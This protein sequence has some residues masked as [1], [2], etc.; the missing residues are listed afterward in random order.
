MLR[1]EPTARG[2]LYFVGCFLP[3]IALWTLKLFYDARY[4]V[5]DDVYHTLYEVISLLALATSVLNIR[6]VAILS[7]PTKKDMLVYIVGIVISYVLAIGRY[8]EVMICQRLGRNGLYPEA[9]HASLRESLWMGF[10]CICYLAAAIVAGVSLGEY[11]SNPVYNDNHTTYNNETYQNE[12][13][14]DDHHRFLAPDES[15]IRVDDRPIYV[16]LGAALASQ[17]AMSLMVLVYMSMVE[18]HKA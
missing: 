16:V 11:P 10:A 15:S 12:T 13:Y 8:V 17:A 9:G 5:G 1:D 6:T 2:L 18:D 3:L 4:F 14:S 7:D